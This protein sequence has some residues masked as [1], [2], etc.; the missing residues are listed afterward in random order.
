MKTNTKIF[1]D[2][3]L[4]VPV[5]FLLNVLAKSLGFV[6]RINHQFTHKEVKHIVICKYLGM[7]SI[8]QA[9]PLIQT[10]KRKYPLAKITFITSAQNKSL[11]AKIP[12]IDNA[13]YINDSGFI[14]LLTSTIN[15]VKVLLSNRADIYLDLEIYSYYST[16]ITTLSCA[17]NR[18]GYYRKESNIR[19]GVYTHMLFFNTHAPIAHSYLQMGRLIGCE[20]IVEDLLPLN[21]S[22]DEKYSL[23]EKFPVLQHQKYIVINANASDLR[24]E[25]RWDSINYIDTIKNLSSKYEQYKFVLIGSKSE[26]HY[27]DNEVYNSLQQNSNVINTCGQ[28]T[29]GELIALIAKCDLILTNDTGPMH[30]A[31]AMK[32]ATVALFGP[33]SPLQYGQNKNAYCIYKSLY[34]SPCVHEFAKAPCGGNNQC[35][36]KIATKEVTDLCISIVSNTDFKDSYCSVPNNFIYLEKTNVPLGI[37]ERKNIK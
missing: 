29:I 18:I 15:A 10:I 19:L 25:R 33:C 34:C 7:G 37:V 24:I 12:L 21:Y 8:I 4:G 17:T 6:L 9:T 35:M 20:D 27:I 16:I 5:V 23:I 30:I 3:F 26:S 36:K 31:F 14:K 22:K 13:I 2:N 32:A 1:I 11:I 28:L